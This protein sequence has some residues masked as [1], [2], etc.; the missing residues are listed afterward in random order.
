MKIRRKERRSEERKG[1]EIG[2]EERDW[3]EEE[4]VCTTKSFM[5]VDNDVQ[6]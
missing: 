5:L 2:E 4:I 1:G 3:K 6:I